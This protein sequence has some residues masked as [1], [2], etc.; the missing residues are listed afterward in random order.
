[1][2]NQGSFGSLP[3]PAPFV[4]TLVLGWLRVRLEPGREIPLH[5]RDSVYLPG[6]LTGK[7]PA[8]EAAV[9]TAWPMHVLTLFWH[10]EAQR[11]KQTTFLGTPQSSPMHAGGLKQDHKFKASQGDLA[12]L[13]LRI[14]I[15]SRDVVLQRCVL[16]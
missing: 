16:A 4:S 14:K 12:R 13:H 2:E 7:T 15:W 3:T 5:L 8:Q 1:M 9:F 10:H 6:S 11:E